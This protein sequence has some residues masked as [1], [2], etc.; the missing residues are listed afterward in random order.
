M[1]SFLTGDVI[2]AAILVVLL[3]L[4]LH[5]I[6]ILMPQSFDMMLLMGCILFFLAF[7]SFVWKEHPQDERENLHRLLAGRTSFLIGTSILVLSIAFQGVMQHTIDPWLIVTL[8]GMVGTK[9]CMQIYSQLR[10]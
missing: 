9:V 7:A 4:L 3:L 5:P 2:I 1:K 10:Q 8:I 6:D